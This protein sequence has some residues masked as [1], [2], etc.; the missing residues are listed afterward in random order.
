MK[1][2]FTKF[3]S[4]N[5]GDDSNAG[6]PPGP[7]VNPPAFQVGDNYLTVAQVNNKIRVTLDLRNHP[8]IRDYNYNHL[9][10]TISKLDMRNINKEHPDGRYSG[11]IVTEGPPKIMELSADVDNTV[12]GENDI[13]MIPECYEDIVFDLPQGSDVVTIQAVNTAGDTFNCGS[14]NYSF[15][16]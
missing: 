14:K 5:S 6:I 12:I 3:I 7:L 4:F 11:W 8:N 10:L 16:E 2:N 9:K 13:I 15:K 1:P